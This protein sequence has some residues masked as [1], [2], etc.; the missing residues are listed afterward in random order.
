M[1]GHPITEGRMFAKNFLKLDI[2]VTVIERSIF[3]H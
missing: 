1:A 2:M 3:S